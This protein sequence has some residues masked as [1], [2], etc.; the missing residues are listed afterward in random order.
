M[1]KESTT[2]LAGSRASFWAPNPMGCRPEMIWP[3]CCPSSEGQA[4]P[5]ATPA[6]PPERAAPPLQSQPPWAN[7]KPRCS[8]CHLTLLIPEPT[9][10]RL[11]M[12]QICLLLP[13]SGHHPGCAAIA[14]LTTAV[15]SF[16]TSLASSCPHW[17][18]H[19]AGRVSFVKHESDHASAL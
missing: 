12:R 11:R 1:S 4:S 7:Q 8:A 16:L 2:R 18:L 3:V 9:G 6:G 17:P 10:R 13:L 5:S 14:C 15:S 19:T